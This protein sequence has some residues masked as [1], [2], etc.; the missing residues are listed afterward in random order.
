[1][2]PSSHTDATATSD[3]ATA[4]PFAESSLSD[5]TAAIVAISAVFLVTV[6]ATAW[7]IRAKVLPWLNSIVGL[8]GDGSSVDGE[9]ETEVLAAVR[10]SVPSAAQVAAG[11]SGTSIQS[12]S[13]SFEGG[14]GVCV[15][16]KRGVT[17][18]AA[19][20]ATAPLGNGMNLR[21]SQPKQLSAA[22]KKGFGR[23]A[24]AAQPAQSSATTA[25][26]VVAAPSGPAG[27]IASIGST[28]ATT[29]AVGWD[30]EEWD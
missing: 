28:N 24:V 20:V 6:V 14:V 4:A 17:P 25:T 12:Q 7:L 18:P 30:D 15:G 22:A 23:A 1:M 3:V 13:R 16:A 2:R 11:R 19:G 10:V 21:S 27:K 9:R 5:S 29:T 8:R 26:G